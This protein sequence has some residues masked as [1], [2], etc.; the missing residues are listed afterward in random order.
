MTMILNSDKNYNDNFYGIKYREW[1]AWL[2]RQKR[3]ES[4]VE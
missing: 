3:Q 4:E 1:E 2:K